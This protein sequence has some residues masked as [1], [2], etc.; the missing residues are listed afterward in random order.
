M[1]TEYKSTKC[2]G[3]QKPFLQKKV[4]TRAFKCYNYLGK[5]KL[6]WR[7]SMLKGNA[8]VGQSGG[9]TAA[10]NATLAGV[11]RGALGAECI[12]KVWGMHNGIEGLL[13]EDLVLLNEIFDTEEK[14]QLLEQ[15]PA[16]AL[17][18]C[19][20][21][22]KCEGDIY[23]NDT[24]NKIF[25]IFNRYNIKYVFYIGGNDSM[26]TAAKLSQYASLMGIEIRIIGVPKTIDNDL[27]LTDHTPGFGSAAKY[28]ATTAREVVR[29][30]AVYKMKAVTIIEIMGREAGWLCASAALGKKLDGAAPDLVY[31]SEC[32]FNMEKCYQDIEKIFENKPNVVIAISEGL[33]TAD[34]KYISEMNSAIGAD[35]FGHRQL[36]GAGK[37]LEYAIKDRFSC[38]VR[39]IE[40]N[41]PQRC[42][43]HLLSA[44]D[45]EES[46]RIG[47]A[48]VELAVE[49]NSGVM[50]AFIRRDSKDYYCDIVA[51]P[52]SEVA[53]AIKYLP[54]EF[55]NAEGN[56]VTDECLEYL[57]P[58]IQGEYPTKWE[59]GMPK[60]IE[61]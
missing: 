32:R 37:A 54:T 16:A 20:L 25:D 42:A 44:T 58:L 51:V 22:L 28:V 27:V 23:K 11:I 19:R 13:K 4:D 47:K 10:I 9:P 8:I 45:I 29:D 43:S 50:P 7:M 53:N 17:G 56:N 15:T 46:V 24:F 30:C 26:D 6:D 36:S 34:G 33:K 60:H 59:N 38:K 49:G 1:I 52:A 3:A 40:L 12:D 18:S 39:S 41:L 2:K 61:I 5:T 57:A 55:I 14:L 21:K 35:A 31:P 48:A